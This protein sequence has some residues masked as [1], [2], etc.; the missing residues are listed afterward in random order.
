[1]RL[2][3]IP[4]NRRVTELVESLGISDLF[5]PQEEAFRTSVL[6][7]RN[8]V[9]A[10]TTGSGKTLVSEMSVLNAILNTGGKA[11]YLVPL[12]SL[13]REKHMDFRKYESLGIRTAM[14]V[15]DYDSPGTR[16]KDAD[17]IILT[18]ERADSLIRHD[19]EWLKDVVIVV[20]DEIHLVNDT[21]RGPTLEMV[22]AKLRM[23][24][25][26]IQIIAL[27]ATISNAHDIAAWLDSELVKSDWRPIP[28]KEGVL[29]DGEIRFSDGSVRVLRQSGKDDVE[30]LI[31][32]M[33]REN[34]QALVF[35]SN[36]RSTVSIAKRLA[37]V[38]RGHLSAES[39]LELLHASKKLEQG[40]AAPEMTEVLISVLRN[41]V[42]FHHAGLTNE[43]RETV[44]DCFRRGLL[45][46]IV[47]TPTLAAGINLPARRS[48]VRDYMRYEEGLGNRPIPVL[49]YKQMAGRAGR[50][51]YD[52]YGEA[53]LIARSYE[54]HDHLM[55]HYVR[56]SSEEIESRLASQS[57]LS[58][59]LLA[60]I[61]SDL[62]HD[63]TGI[64][65]LIRGTFLYT[66]STP[67]SIGRHV[68]K[69]IE[70]LVRSGLVQ[71]TDEGLL[72]A[73]PL[74][75]RCSQL[76][77]SPE[78]ALLFAE[79]LP[80][81]EGFTVLSI[82][83]MICHTPDQPLAYLGRGELTEYEEFVEANLDSFAFEP[84]DASEFPEEY[85]RYL[86]ELKTARLLMD[87]ISE[88]SDRNLTDNYNVGMGDVHRLAQSAEWLAYSAEEIARLMGVSVILPLLHETKVRL[89]YGVRPDI[90]ELVGLRGIG[91]VR[92][93]MLYRSGF[94]TLSNLYSA[95]LENLA[96]VPSIGSAVA[97]SIK[98]Q[99]GLEVDSNSSTPDTESS[100]ES[101][102]T[103]LDDFGDTS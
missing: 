44:E 54:E 68:S 45:K 16:L 23:K 17:V 78:T 24:L 31:V 25:K 79:A 4:I 43:E 3:D 39:A 48:I 36:R 82:L 59:H 61:A 28:L 63:R 51:G 9:M 95:S 70:Y 18:T 19:V 88:M 20:V 13:A 8:L 34:G 5:P 64:D 80:N 11:L 65:N 38:V 1:M 32:D 89:R 86:S 75:K 74:G 53:V 90:L 67:V 62:T 55:D 103:V 100:A 14:S 73:T 41:G 57:A 84:P 21:S 71:R 66:K 92:G 10:A 27:S 22:I 96:R 15:G 56:A 81:A 37:S 7:G 33:L 40:P 6:S 91:R 93:R 2:R 35:A 58:T 77:I 101:F 12:K 76:Y 47:A 83:Q 97:E 52:S 98:R 94:K 99:L 72:V 42:A 60:A 102:Q 29:L 87:W 30:N 49:E 46:V 85:S 26:K 69:S 50:P